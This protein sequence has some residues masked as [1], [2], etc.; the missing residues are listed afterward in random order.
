M[1]TASS[2]LG[3]ED[4]ERVE[5]AV[6]AAEA[7]TSAEI[8]PAV[9]TSSGRYDRAED[10]AGVWLSALLLVVAWLVMPWERSELGDW[11]M[12]WAQ[13]QLPMLLGALLAGFVTGA[14]LASRFWW[15]R[16]L[17]TPRREMREEVEKRAR[18]LFFDQRIHHTS[19]ATGVLLYVSLYERMAAVIAD[20]RATE[21]LGQVQLDQLCL[22]L[23]TALRGGSVPEALSTVIAIAGEQLSAVL[24]RDANDGNELGDALI[25]VD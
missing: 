5:A 22:D 14:V 4:R 18:Q 2:L 20:E 16:R 8:V 3:Q 24:P 21:L 6:K 12:S 17:F 7:R 13:F 19:G 1:K 10:I 25:L 9:G 11:G 23:T 15:L